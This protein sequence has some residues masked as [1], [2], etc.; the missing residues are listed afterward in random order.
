MAELVNVSVRE[1][2]ARS[3]NTSITLLIVV[4]G[5]ALF[6]GAAIRPLLY[7]M[8][9]GVTVGTYSSIFIAS[10]ILVAWE[11]GELGRAFRRIPLVGGRAR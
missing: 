11:E 6:A 4:L 7:V 5:L 10:L 2:V 3:L 1:T 9:A 8:L